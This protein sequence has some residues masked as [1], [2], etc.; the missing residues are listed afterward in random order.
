[1]IDYTVQNKKR[2]ILRALSIILGLFLIIGVGSALYVRNQYNNSLEPVGGAQRTEFV[3][4]KGDTAHEIALNLRQAGL[5]RAEWAF[6]WYVR[7][8]GYR[9]QFLAGSYELSPTQSTPEI[10]ADL[11]KGNVAK[12]LVTILPGQRI[13]EIRDDLI[14]FGFEPA[15]VDVALDPAQYE[16]HPALV[17]KPVGASLEGYIYPESFQTTGDT[18]PETIIRQSLDLMQEQLTPDIRAA[19]AAQGITTHQGIILASIVMQE[20]NNPD[21]AATAAQV[22]LKRFREGMV[23]GSDVTARYG[24]VIDGVYLPE[25]SAEADSIAIAHDSPY[26]TRIY[27]GFPPGPISNVSGAYIRAAAFPTNTDY[28]YFVAGD[29]GVTHFTRTLEEHDAAVA[30]YCFELCGR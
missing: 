7:V 19:F 12:D 20:S 23:F 27:S 6:E 25:N 13:D 28:L 17:D 30:Q 29:D 11:I 4:K 8:N 3:V 16:G 22:F 2:H 1:M 21:D 24:A 15:A 14:D 5:I 26:N 18:A 9:D 10:V